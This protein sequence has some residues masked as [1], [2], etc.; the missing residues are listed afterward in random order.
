VLV[1]LAELYYRQEDYAKARSEID[2]AMQIQ[3]NALPAEHPDLMWSRVTLGKILT[4]TG[5]LGEAESNLRSALE[6]LSASMPLDHPNLASAR[7]AL[8]ECLTSQARHS[9]AEPLLL[10]SYHVAQKRFGAADPRTHIA[11]ERLVK[12]YETWGKP[13][14]AERYRVSAPPPE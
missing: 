13:E 6:K 12:L 14:E 10:D 11:Q 1:T 3:Q 9:E 2:R 5:A 7:G 8:G 4:R